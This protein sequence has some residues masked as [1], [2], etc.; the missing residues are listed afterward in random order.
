MR[1][2]LG[3]SESKRTKHKGS[4]ATLVSVWLNEDVLSRREG[5]QQFPRLRR[6]YSLEHRRAT[7]RRPR[8]LLHIFEE[9]GYST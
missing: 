6:A 1:M 7:C 4:N 3:K 5:S 2:G 8:L 9:L